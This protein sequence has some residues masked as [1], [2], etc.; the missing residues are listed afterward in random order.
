MY[1]IR[2]IMEA[3]FVSIAQMEIEISKISF[4]EEAITDIEFHKNKIADAFRKDNKGML[5]LV[6]DNKVLGWLWMDKKS[7][8][9]TKE[10]YV[11]F[12]SFYI[13][14]SIRGSEY[15]DRLMIEGVDYVKSIKAK[16]ITGKVH[17]DNLP[18]RAL[19]KNHGFKPTHIT[20]EIDLE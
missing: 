7:N 16:H 19:Y 1:L 10:I 12:R 11:N 4:Q 2:H 15:A 5:V 20:M 17:V 8:Y 18:M 14:T 9:L 13:D 3:D 6:E